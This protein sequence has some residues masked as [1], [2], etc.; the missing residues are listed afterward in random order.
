MSTAGVWMLS[1]PKQSGGKVVVFLDHNLHEIHPDN[2][3]KHDVWISS[4][5]SSPDPKRRLGALLFDGDKR[6]PCL[7]CLRFANRAKMNSWVKLKREGKEDQAS[8]LV[9]PPPKRKFPCIV[10]DWLD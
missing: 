1:Y 9:I 8:S 2:K 4:V 6:F 3:G 10:P 7:G 5:P